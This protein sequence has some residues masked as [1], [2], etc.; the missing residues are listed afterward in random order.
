MTQPTGKPAPPR[1]QF[2]NA[3]AR[4]ITIGGE[5]ACRRCMWCVRTGDRHQ[6][7]VQD[8]PDADRCRPERS[9]G[10]SAGNLQSILDG[11]RSRTSRAL[12]LMSQESTAPYVCQCG[13]GFPTMAYLAAHM[14]SNHS[15]YSHPSKWQ[16]RK[17]RLQ[18]DGTKA[19]NL[20]AYLAAW[21]AL[22]R[23]IEAALGLRTVY[24]DPNLLLQDPETGRTLELSVAMALKLVAA[25]QPR[26]PVC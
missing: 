20:E 8:S 7:P 26:L 11:L 23:P 18:P 10:A 15:P 4:F 14:L 2:C 12:V 17:D 1:C 13:D 22:K 19:A 25:I 16:K 6:P 5:P 3:V 9:Q 21:E 24:Y